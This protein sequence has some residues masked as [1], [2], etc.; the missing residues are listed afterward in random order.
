VRQIKATDRHAT[1]K[2]I[3]A[4][5][6]TIVLTVGGILG[7]QAIARPPAEPPAVVQRSVLDKKMDVC[8]AMPPG[9]SRSECYVRIASEQE[10]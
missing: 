1:A 7:G 10:P 8:R 6:S 3:G 2:L 5:I 9:P 4:A